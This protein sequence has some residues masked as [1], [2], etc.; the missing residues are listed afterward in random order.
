MI[1]II[2]GDITKIKVDA[3]V[4][5]ANS[6][7]LGGGG[8]D[9]AIHRAGGKLIFEDCMKIHNKQGGCKVGEAVITTAGNLPAKFVIHT[10][11]PIWNGGKDSEDQLLSNA[12]RNSLQLAIDNKVKTISF[13]NISTGVYGFPKEKAATIALSTVVDY[14]KTDNSITDVIFVCYDKENY[15]IY[16]GLIKDEKTITPSLSSSKNEYMNTKFYVDT[17][18]NDDN[19]YRLAIQF[20]CKL[21]QKDSSIKRI[22]LY[23]ATKQNTGW[24]GR[25]FGNDF[26]KRAFDGVKFPDCSAIF[27]F[28]TKI[29]YKSFEYGNSSDII[30]CCGIDSDDILT[31]DDYSSVKYIIAV[32]WLKKLTEKWI[33]TW[34]AI[35]IS[36]KKETEHFPELS[37]IVK[38]AMTPLSQTINMSTGISHPLDNSR[39]KTYV[40]ALYKY[41]SELNANAVGAYLIR[42]LHWETKHAKDIEN[43][44]ITLNNGKYFQ[45]G[46]KTGLQKYYKQW[47]NAIK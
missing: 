15:D 43:L 25:L 10:G 47:K 27:K 41:E 3:I 42:E 18:G 12:Y 36:G 39:A 24:F 26:V 8:V 19:A 31:I 14:L 35:E 6:S 20:A 29:T 21:A 22:V 32:P 33:K 4:N 2:Q 46:E 38:I 1:K 45:G 40:R 17:E 23:I 13:P 34:N 7:L 11:G 9:G 37:P 16:Q 30:I 5:A 28:E 44:I